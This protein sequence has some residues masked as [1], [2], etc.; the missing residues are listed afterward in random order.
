MG[1]KNITF[2]QHYL[3]VHKAIYREKE[4]EKA[5]IMDESLGF[6]FQQ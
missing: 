5:K 1:L 2:V 6:S 3:Y 4:I